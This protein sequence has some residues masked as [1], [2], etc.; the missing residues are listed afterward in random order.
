MPLQDDLVGAREPAVV[1]VGAD[2]E[3]VVNGD[4]EWYLNQSF[5]NDSPVGP[6]KHYGGFTSANQVVLQKHADGVARLAT[7]VAERLTNSG[8]R[9]KRTVGECAVGASDDACLTAFIRSFGRRALR[10]PVTDE[11][12]AFYRQPAVAVPYTAEDYAD[13]ITLLMSAPESLFLVEHGDESVTAAVAPLTPHEL[14]SRLSFH[15]WQTTPDE[16]LLASADSGEL[17]TEAGFAA[18]VDRLFKHER[19]RA[20]VGLFFDEWLRNT[21]LQSPD[22]LIGNA[23]FDKL[24]GDYTPVKETRDRM[25]SEVTDAALYYTF[26]KPGT[27][28]SFFR[29]T[30]SFAR[31]PDVAQLYGVPVWDGVSEPPEAPGRAG[32]ITRPALVATGSAGSRIIMKGVFIRKNLL[33]DKL[34]DPPA[35][36]GSSPPAEPFAPDDTD[37]VH[38]DKLTGSGSCAG[39]H[40]ALINDLGFATQNFDSLGRLRTS[41][42]LLDGDGKELAPPAAIDTSAMPHIAGPTDETTVANAQELVSLMADS[43]KLDACFARTYFR[44]TFGRSEDPGTKDKPGADSCAL[45]H[46]EKSLRQGSDLATVLRS[47]ALHPSFKSRSFQ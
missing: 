15:F 43:P 22:G 17:G 5:P 29:S 1:L 40:T 36:A 9:L 19:T 12:V 45:A 8:G 37:R 7:L 34:G 31:T 38:I 10:R 28:D 33:C 25:W 13:V 35:N 30:R 32:L 16:A 46:I 14:A 6:D 27:F 42:L 21:T 20:S 23:R 3:D 26:D 11:D 4:L 18:Q 2:G 44:Y 24:R 41:E 47:V 39:C